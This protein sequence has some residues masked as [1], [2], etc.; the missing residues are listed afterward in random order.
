MDR[1][2]QAGQEITDT[3]KLLLVHAFVDSPD[4]FIAALRVAPHVFKG[5]RDEAQI[6]VIVQVVA[7]HGLTPG[8]THETVT[9]KSPSA[10]QPEYCPFALATLRLLDT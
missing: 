6:P 3:Q 7:I 10:P 2:R 4:A 9:I 1:S 5:I 8:S